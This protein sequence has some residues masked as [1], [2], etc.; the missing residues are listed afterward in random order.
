MEEPK[1][2]APK[3]PAEP[4]QPMIGSCDRMWALVAMKPKTESD[5]A[6]SKQGAKASKN[7]SGRPGSDEANAEVRKVWMWGN[8]ALHKDPSKDET[9][10][11]EASGEAVYLDNRGTNNA[12]TYIYQRDPTERTYLPG[13]LPPAHVENAE[14]NITAAGTIGMDQGAD[15][16]WVE[17]PGTLTQWTDRGFLTDKS[18]EPDEPEPDTEAT[19]GQVTKTGND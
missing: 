9:K 4:E 8:V 16:A 10:G 14:I 18:G 1:D 6:S 3:E 17:G 7:A 5:L 15:L 11:E 2:E 19:D 12:L 13:P